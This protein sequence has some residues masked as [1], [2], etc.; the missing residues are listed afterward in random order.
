MPR[1]AERNDDAFDAVGQLGVADLKRPRFGTDADAARAA[2]HARL[3]DPHRLLEIVWVCFEE[4]RGV[5]V[6]VLV[7]TD[8]IGHLVDRLPDRLWNDDFLIVVR[9]RGQDET[10]K[11]RG[12]DAHDGPGTTVHDLALPSKWRRDP[13]GGRS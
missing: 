9:Q 3:V 8:I 11:R 2:R 12:G 5:L 7:F 6:D 1:I 13:G 4:R 10:G